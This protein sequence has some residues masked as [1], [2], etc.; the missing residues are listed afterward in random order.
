MRDTGTQWE[1][2]CGFF[3]KPLIPGTIPKKYQQGDKFKAT[4]LCKGCHKVEV[5]GIARLCGKCADERQRKAK[6]DSARQK[7]SN[8]DKT[9]NSPIGAEALT[10]ADLAFVGGG[11]GNPSSTRD[12]DKTTSGVQP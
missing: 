7:R 12:V 4:K 9:E 2:R 1:C 5:K 10:N 6:R 3:Y 11:A 8:V